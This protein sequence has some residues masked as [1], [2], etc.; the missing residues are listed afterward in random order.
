MLHSQISHMLSPMQTW[1]RGNSGTNRQAGALTISKI[2]MEKLTM[3]THAVCTVEEVLYGTL[4]AALL[5]WKLLSKTLMG[6][7]TE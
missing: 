1:I 2:H 6:L 5:F 3:Q 4:Q 7:Q